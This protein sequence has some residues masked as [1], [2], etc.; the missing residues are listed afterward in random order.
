MRLIPRDE[1]YFEQLNEL[2][3]A[4]H[5]GADRLRLLFDDLRKKTLYLK[6]IKDI[7]HDCDRISG[8][9][10]EHLN[11]S[12]ITPI[13]REDIY[14]L[15][16]ELDDV[17]DRINDIALL[18]VLYGV[19]TTTDSARELTRILVSVALELEPAIL[20]LRSRGGVREHIERI[21][22]LEED[23]DRVWQAAVQRLFADEKNPIELVRWLGLYEK[24]EAGIDQCKHVAKTLEAIVV[25]NA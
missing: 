19:E 20:A 22:S 17:M 11:A 1:K 13:D 7:E 18:T 15:A 2:V 16:T 21:K 10:I 24:L 23:G 3:A 14:L 9:I 4:I 6:E 5:K 12:F 25:K 8:G